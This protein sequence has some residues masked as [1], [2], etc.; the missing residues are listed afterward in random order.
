MKAQHAANKNNHIPQLRH[1]EID[2][3]SYRNQR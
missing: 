3:A 2:P 1:E